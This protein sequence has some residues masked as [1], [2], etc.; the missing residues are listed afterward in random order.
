M[1]CDREL[2][3]AKGRYLWK[4]R[5]LSADGAN[6][7]ACVAQGLDL[8]PEDIVVQTGCGAILSNMFQLLAEPGE[9]VLIPAPYYPAFENDMKVCT[10]EW[11]V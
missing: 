4:T 8:S 9:S 11:T 10:T 5:W 1:L 7:V 6:A 3:V 2:L